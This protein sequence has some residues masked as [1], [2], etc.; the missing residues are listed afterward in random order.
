MCSSVPEQVTTGSSWPIGCTVLASTR[1]VL[2]QFRATTEEMNPFS[3]AKTDA[4]RHD[5]PVCGFIL[6]AV[7]MRSR[8]RS[9]SPNLGFCAGSRRILGPFRAVRHQIRRQCGRNFPFGRARAA[10]NYAKLNGRPRKLSNSTGRRTCLYPP[11]FRRT[12]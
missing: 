12:S 3:G 2:P 8:L 5:C 1:H 10:D 4:S 11:G 7:A 6:R 9:K